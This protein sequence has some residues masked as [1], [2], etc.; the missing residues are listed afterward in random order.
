MSLH[1]PGV[2]A[3]LLLANSTIPWIWA[4][5]GT[6]ASGVLTLTTGIQSYQSGNY[7]VY[8]YL[9]ASASATAGWYP[10]TFTSATVCTVYQQASTWGGTV[11]TTLNGAYTAVG[12][13]IAAYQSVSVPAN[14]MG[15]NGVL[16]LTVDAAGTSN[17]SN[18]YTQYRW[19]GTGVNGTLFDNAS[20]GS[21]TGYT[22]IRMIRNRNNTGFQVI[23]GTPGGGGSTSGGAHTFASVDTTASVPIW[24]NLASG[25]QPSNAEIVGYSLEYLA[26]V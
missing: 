6:A 25:T 12:S 16:R 13:E 22:S 2:K 20:I 9:A 15:L 26:G 19:G 3:P 18:W 21:T 4:G 14:L 8:V 23:S 10:A 17:A 11:Y 24:L 1:F 5:S 7:N